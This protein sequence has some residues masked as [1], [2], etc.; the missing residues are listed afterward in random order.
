MRR[1]RQSELQLHQPLPWSLYDAQ[2]NLLL[3]QGFVLSIPRHV[4]M[5]LH[6]GV[7]VHDED[8]GMPAATET[9]AAAMVSSFHAEP[10]GAA[11][12]RHERLPE[13]AGVG[14]FYSDD[15][16]ESGSDFNRR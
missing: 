8:S 10:A 11:P 6:R 13:A 16:D 12:E 14:Q 4:D 15:S 9:S 2:G 3:R 7:Y 5:L 1:I